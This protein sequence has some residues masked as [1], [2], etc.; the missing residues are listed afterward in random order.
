LKEA[1]ESSHSDISSTE[2][3]QTLARQPDDS[4]ITIDLDEIDSNPQVHQSRISPA[5][6]DL[7]LE[8][9]PMEVDPINVDFEQLD[10]VLIPTVQSLNSCPRGQKTTSLSGNL[11]S[12]PY[13]ICFGMVSI[14][15]S[16]LH[17]GSC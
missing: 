5:L 4:Y 13:D 2:L 17:S 9:D 15:R 8:D 10:P 3:K 14:S 11:G 7:T 1:S 16:G 6:I 12:T